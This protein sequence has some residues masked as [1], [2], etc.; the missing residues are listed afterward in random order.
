MSSNFRIIVDP[1]SEAFYNNNF[2]VDSVFN[3][4]DCL[5]PN[6]RLKAFLN[7]QNIGIDTFDMMPTEGRVDYY[8]FGIL[9]NIDYCLEQK[10]VKMKAFFIMEPPCVMPELYDQLPRLTKIFENVYIHNTWGS[11]YSLEGVDKDKLKKLY[12]AQSYNYVLEN[13]WSNKKKIKKV[14]VI[15][16]NKKPKKSS[17]ELYSERIKAV[18]QLSKHDYVDLYGMNWDRLLSTTTFWPPFIFNRSKILSVYKG[19][20]KSKHEVLSKYDFCLCYEND[21]VDSYI[22][23]KIFDCFYSGTIPIY[24]GPSDIDKYI[25]KEAFIDARSF[26]NYTEM[27]KYL[28]KLSDEQKNRYVLQGRRFI[29]GK[30]M[31][32]FFNSLIDIFTKEYL[33]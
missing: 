3:R 21:I 2:F 26:D 23:E 8:S 28:S 24:L 9:S 17:N 10:E 5:L 7:E 25:P 12:W 32:K 16:A 29:E 14:V 6:I 30:G 15:N 11:G 22:T 4:D 33:L 31:N 27:Y 1:P 13:Y 20:A 19:V 18:V